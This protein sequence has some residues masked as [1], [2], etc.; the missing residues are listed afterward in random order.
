LFVPFLNAG[1]ANIE[2]A[3]SDCL[4]ELGDLAHGRLYLERARRSEGWKEGVK[5]RIELIESKIGMNKPFFLTS[6]QG[7]FNKVIHSSWIGNFL[8]ILAFLLSFIRVIIKKKSTLIIAGS[9][10][11]ILL[12]SYL[13]VIYPLAVVGSPLQI[14]DKKGVSFILPGHLVQILGEKGDQVFVL[15]EKGKK[16]FIEQ[17]KLLL[18]D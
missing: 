16:G 9:L 14:F 3:V 7:V 17:K 4:I 11:A 12:V 18:V 2:C 10:W 8:F 1:D 5:Q 13:P 15:T 6:W